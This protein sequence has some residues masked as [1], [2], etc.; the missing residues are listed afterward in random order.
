MPIVL[1]DVWVDARWLGALAGVLPLLA[2]SLEDLHVTVFGDPA[3]TEGEAAA[4]EAYLSEQTNLSA[5]N[6]SNSRPLVIPI[7][8]CGGAISFAT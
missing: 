1:L 6:V 2:P 5:L 7:A 3:P 4:L 8:S